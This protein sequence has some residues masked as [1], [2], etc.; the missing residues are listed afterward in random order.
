MGTSYTYWV[1]QVTEDATPLP[2]PQKL[3][4]Q[5]IFSCQSKPSDLDYLWNRA[6]T[7]EEKNV[8]KWATDRLMVCFLLSLSVDSSSPNA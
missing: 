5:D 3:S 7:W 6:R 4:P 8:N 2:V 1:R